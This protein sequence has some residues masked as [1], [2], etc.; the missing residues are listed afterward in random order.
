[1]T[2]ETRYCRFPLEQAERLALALSKDNDKLTEYFYL[3]RNILRAHVRI[4]GNQELWLLN[5]HAEAFSDDKIRHEHILTFLEVMSELADKGA[6][7]GWR[8][9]FQLPSRLVQTESKDF[10]DDCTNGRFDND[11]YTGEEHW[12][13]RP[14]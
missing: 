4:P 2:R 9:R 11:D 14:V 5:M 13:E 3:K 8:R 6:T 7:G 10:P 1:L 12:L